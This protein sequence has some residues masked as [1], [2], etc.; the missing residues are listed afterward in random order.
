MSVPNFASIRE[1]K[2]SGDVWGDVVAPYIASKVFEC[3]KVEAYED[4]RL[5]PPELEEYSNEMLTLLVRK[6]G[7][8]KVSRVYL[9]VGTRDEAKMANC[10]LDGYVGRFVV[11][12][13]VVPHDVE[14]YNKHE[15]IQESDENGMFADLEVNKVLV[16]TPSSVKRLDTDALVNLVQAAT[17]AFVGK[18]IELVEG[19]NEIIG[20]FVTVRV[21]RRGKSTLF[22]EQDILIGNPDGIRAL[23]ETD[24]SDESDADSDYSTSDRILGAGQHSSA[25]SSESSNESSDDEESDESS[26]DESSDD[27]EESNDESSDDEEESNDESS[28]DEES[29]GVPEGESEEEFEGE[30]EGESEEE[31]VD[32]DSKEEDRMIEEAKVMSILPLFNEFIE[33]YNPEHVTDASLRLLLDKMKM[34]GQ[35]RTELFGDDD[36]EDDEFTTNDAH[37]DS[38]LMA[39]MAALNRTTL[40][41]TNVTTTSPEK[42]TDDASAVVPD[43]LPTAGAVQVSVEDKSS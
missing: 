27:E 33:L 37:A 22:E 20:L 38:A 16:S 26:D 39:I 6:S 25:H 1:I 5:I 8:D 15:I 40:S 34:I 17:E 23:R 13:S 14:F 29:E 4:I 30:S 2:S 21:M 10:L 11:V 32:D 12:Q 36:F 42:T 28:D 41:G 24:D 18:L 7:S 31:E 9:W 3:S 35:V 43:E 19:G